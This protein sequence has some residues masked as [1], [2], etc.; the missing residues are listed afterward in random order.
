[1]PLPAYQFE[2]HYAKSTLFKTLFSPSLKKKN[3][4]KKQRNTF[5]SI[6][7]IKTKHQNLLI[8]FSSF[9]CKFIFI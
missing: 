5:E 8:A 6:I 9:H 1:M 2:S 3:K 4:L 7:E